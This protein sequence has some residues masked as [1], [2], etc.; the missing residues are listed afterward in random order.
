MEEREGMRDKRRINSPNNLTAQVQNQHHLWFK[1]KR[2]MEAKKQEKSLQSNFLTPN[3][4]R[5][6]HWILIQLAHT[7]HLCINISF[8]C[9]ILQG[10]TS[11]KAI[12]LPSAKTK[13]RRRNEKVLKNSNPLGQWEGGCAVVWLK[14]ITF[15]QS[16][17]LTVHLNVASTVGPQPELC[18]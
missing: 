6:R 5:G 8:C 13:K 10:Q 7:P 1:K 11:H 18:F 16:R 9:L 15:I 3:S 12:A 2:R 17:L 14:W 4:Q